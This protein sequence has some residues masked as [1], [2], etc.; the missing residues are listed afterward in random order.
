VCDSSA[1][2]FGKAYGKHK[3]YPEVSPK[4]SWEGAIAGLIGAIVSFTLLNYFFI[5]QFPILYSLIAGVLI[6]I[7]GQI[8]D[9]AESQLKRDAGIKDS[10]D[11]LPGHGGILDRF[12]SALFVFPVLTIFLFVIAA[13]G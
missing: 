9:L 2:F 12:D 11:L 7:T 5:P 8:G 4:K 13:F 1:Y 6:G 3:L 10:S